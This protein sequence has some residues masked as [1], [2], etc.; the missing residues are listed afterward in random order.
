MVLAIAKEHRFLA[1]HVRPARRKDGSWYS[2]IMG[3]VGFPDYIF[4]FDPSIG[5]RVDVFGAEIKTGKATLAD[6]QRVW[7]HA[8]EHRIPVYEWH[9]PEDEAA[10]R[11]RFAMGPDA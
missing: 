6:G 11:R 3:D 2:P 9:W 7:K 1:F 5:A 10:I 4:A 8:L